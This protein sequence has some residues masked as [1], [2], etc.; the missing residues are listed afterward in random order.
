MQGFAHEVQGDTYH[1][2]CLHA[3]K[4]GLPK[5]ES[6]EA[7]CEGDIWYVF[8]PYMIEIFDEDVAEK[9]VARVLDKEK[10]A[11][12]RTQLQADG[13]G[14]P[15]LWFDMP[16]YEYPKHIHQGKVSFYIIHGSVTFSGG[17]EKTVS[18]G[19]RMDVPVGVYHTAITGSEGC[20]YLVGQEIEGD[21]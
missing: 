18:I 3:Q 7:Y 9:E 8:Y 2:T 6:T 19:E 5:P 14:T 21:A 20:V 10:I 13:F 1:S 12:L 16:N 15:F 11:T 17:I 4:Q